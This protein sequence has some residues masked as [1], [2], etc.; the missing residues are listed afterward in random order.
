MLP[1]SLAL[2]VSVVVLLL[3]SVSPPSVV[4]SW[5][6]V[7]SVSLLPLLYEPVSVLPLPLPP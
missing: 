7:V 4:L 2:A 1:L 6:V 3:L 5:T